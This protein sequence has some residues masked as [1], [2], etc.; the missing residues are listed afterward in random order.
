MLAGY[1]VFAASAV[2]LFRLAGRD[3]HAPQPVWFILV[4]VLSGM[5]F[6]W[7]GGRLAMRVAPKHPSRHAIAVAALI[8]TGATV[9]LF[10]SP[11]ADASWSQGAALALMAPCAWLATR[12]RRS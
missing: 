6:A 11:S 2:A 5:L 4:A 3:P 10:T 12:P 8:A 1:T 9:S 7:L